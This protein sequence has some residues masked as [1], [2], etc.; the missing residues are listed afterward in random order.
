MNVKNV[1]QNDL[2]AKVLKPIGTYEKVKTAA[3]AEFGKKL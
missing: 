2:A 3:D 1:W